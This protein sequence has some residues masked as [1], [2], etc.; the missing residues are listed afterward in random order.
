MEAATATEARAT[1]RTWTSK[2]QLLAGLRSPRLSPVDGFQMMARSSLPPLNKRD[3]SR[4][5]HASD[6]TPFWWPR[7]RRSGALCGPTVARCCQGRRVSDRRQW[8]RRW[9]AVGAAGHPPSVAQVPDQQ[10]RIVVVLRRGDDL[11]G[12]GWV[13]RNRRDVRPRRLRHDRDGL[14]VVLQVPDHGGAC[15]ASS[16]RGEGRAMAARVPR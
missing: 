9:P 15:G 16:H 7:S 8:G 6:S 12:R 3:G 11:H 13:P 4:G 1:S 14:A 5:H 2:T 10:R